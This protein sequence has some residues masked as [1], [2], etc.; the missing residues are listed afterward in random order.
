LI[1]L[2]L[3]TGG[4]SADL[5]LDAVSHAVSGVD[6]DVRSHREPREDLDLRVSAVADRDRHQAGEAVVDAEGP[7]VAVPEDGADRRLRHVVGLPR[8][9]CAP[10]KNPRFRA[11]RIARRAELLTLVRELLDVGA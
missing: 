9:T 5:D 8:K 4:A 2:P 7:L 11:R 3:M 6:H 10:V 1:A